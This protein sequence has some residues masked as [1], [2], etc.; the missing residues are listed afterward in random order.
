MRC[1]SALAALAALGTIAALAAPP[2]ETSTISLVVS[3]KCRPEKRPAFREHLAGEAATRLVAWQKERRLAEHLLLFGWDVSD[4][5]WDALLVL[6]FDSWGQYAQWK[7]T[8]RAFPAA[9]SVEALALTSAVS[10]SLAELAWRGGAPEAKRPATAPVYFVRPYYY[11]DKDAYRGFFDA[12]NAPQFDAWLR[13]GAMNS[14]LALLNQNPTG[15][16]W[17]ALLIYEY[18]SWEA[19]SARDELKDSVG[20]ELRALRGWTVLGEVKGGIR[21][22]GRVTLAERLSPR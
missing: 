12:Y 22:S 1:V 2:P 15:G 20:P 14:Y 3:Y 8:E 19:A 18:S 11:E 10:S 9:L 21:K 5:L 7:E 4:E 17:G 6:R 16:A 13:V